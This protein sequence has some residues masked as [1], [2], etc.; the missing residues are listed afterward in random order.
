MLEQ[1]A[2]IGAF[3][4]QLPT[5]L[6][7]LD[8]CTDPYHEALAAMGASGIFRRVVGSALVAIFGGGIPVSICPNRSTAAFTRLLVPFCRPCFLATLAEPWRLVP[9]GTDPHRSAAL[10]TRLLVPFGVS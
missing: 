1:F 6:L 9:I 4:W 8:L 5:A 3:F 7:T 2:A 10:L